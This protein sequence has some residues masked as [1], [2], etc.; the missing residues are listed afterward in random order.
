MLTNNQVKHI[1][2][3]KIKKYRDEYKEFIAEGSTLVT[4]LIRSSYEIAAVYA[5]TQWITNNLE[6]I[7][8]RNVPV[9]EAD[10][11]DIE[12]ITS[13]TNPSSVL[14]IVRIPQEVDLSP[15]TM[16]NVALEQIFPL[17]FNELSLM[18][19]GISDP[20]NFGTMLRIA[21][22]FGIRNLFCSENCVEVYNPKVVQASMGSVARVNVVYTELA[23]FLKKLNGRLPVYGTFL[24]GESI[25]TKHL[26]EH[27]IIII[28]SEAHGIS[29]KLAAFVTGQLFIPSFG[30]TG[31]GKAESL[32]AAV[33]AAVVIA[34]FRRRVS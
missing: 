33:A 34:E 31:N 13:L 8:Q 11:R 22:W 27:G 28:G 26:A 10:P 16:E 15:A 20:G 17:L 30:S 32:N 3:L 6:L 19:E 21:D 5:E 12:R 14:A 23:G 18:L 29:E 24:Q 7:R 25:Y 9:Y 2:A 1:N 4:D